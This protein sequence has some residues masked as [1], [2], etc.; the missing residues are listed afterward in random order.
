MKYILGI[1]TS[2][3]TTSL[4]A[5]DHATGKMIAD[6]RKMLP[7]EN[8]EKGLRQAEAFFYHIQHLPEVMSNLKCEIYK[9]ANEKPEWQAI[10]VSVRPRPFS[11]SYMPVFL[12]GQSFAQ[13][14]GTTLS[15]PVIQTSH[16]EG[17]IAAAHY[18]LPELK[19][20]AFIAV[21]LSGGTS[22]VMVARETSFGYSVHLVGEGLDLHAGQ[23]IDRV[24]VAIGLSFPT[25]P[26]LEQIAHQSINEKEPLFYLP[27][28]VK[29]AGMSF[30]GPCSAAL[31]ALANGTSPAVVARAVE[32]SIANAVIKSISHAMNLYTEI[33][34]CVIAGGVASNLWIRQRILKRMRILYPHLEIY[35]APPKYSSDNA[36]GVAQ[37]AYRFLAD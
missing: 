14:L 13:T 28:S 5:V 1:D 17:H 33:R 15:V 4:C 30:S 3:Y 26:Q 29:N 16:Q 10:G 9:Y 19:K 37:I 18:F 6:A 25:G 35:F 7:V 11:F 23:F 21:H 2:N 27:S 22:D 32:T 12:A 34:Q 36:L 8:G 31:R 24:G 20:E